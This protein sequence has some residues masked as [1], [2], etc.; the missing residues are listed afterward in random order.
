MSK[1]ALQEAGLEEAGPHGME[2]INTTQ[3]KGNEDL[4]G[5]VAGEGI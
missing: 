5:M 1:A 2:T 4:E 3:V